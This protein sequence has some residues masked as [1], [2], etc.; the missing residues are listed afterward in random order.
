MVRHISLEEQGNFTDSVVRTVYHPRSRIAGKLP[1]RLFLWLLAF[2]VTTQC[3]MSNL[4]LGKRKESQQFGLT[5]PQT[6]KLVEGNPQ[7]LWWPAGRMRAPGAT[8]SHCG[9]S[10]MSR[11]THFLSH[12]RNLLSQ[13]ITFWPP[14]NSD[15]ACTEKTNSHFTQITENIPDLLKDWL[16]QNVIKRSSGG[17]TGAQWCTGCFQNKKR[18]CVSVMTV[19]IWHT[20]NTAGL[21][22]C[23]L[24]I[25]LLG[26]TLVCHLGFVDTHG[27]NLPSS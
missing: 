23:N 17:T 13:L 12:W 20:L 21:S 14:I 11:Q 10:F 18:T 4:P 19:Y 24:V 27:Q 15:W 26:I 5:R 22:V 9:G 8:C 6:K 16:Q 3:N 25:T 2:L 1:A 7:K